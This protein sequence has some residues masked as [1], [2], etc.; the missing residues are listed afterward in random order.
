MP[1]NFSLLVRLISL[2][3]GHISSYNSLQSWRPFTIWSHILCSCVHCLHEQNE[4]RKIQTVG[5]PWQGTPAAGIMVNI[6]DELGYRCEDNPSL[7]IGAAS[8]WLSKIPLNKQSE[9]YYYTTEGVRNN[10]AALA[11]V[12]MHI[13]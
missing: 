7:G 10:M 9:V 13:S 12:A 11:T 1:S 5:T 2:N 3:P 4:G 8:R 6:G